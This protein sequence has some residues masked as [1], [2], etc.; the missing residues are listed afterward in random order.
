[1]H[2]SGTSLLASLL[3]GAGLHMGDDLLGAGKGNPEGHFE[4][5]EFYRLHLRM[6][7]G[8]GLSADGFTSAESIGVPPPCHE[9][10]SELVER[11]R[12]AGRPWGWK[13]PR[14]ILFLDFWADLLPESRWLFVV[15]PPWEV[16][17]S[18]YRRG[19]TAFLANPRFAA[20]VWVAYN[21]RIL[22]FV[23]SM[24]ARAAVVHTEQVIGDPAGV[25]QLAAE[26][27]C[28]PLASPPTRF[29]KEL[30]VTGLPAHCA[31]LVH[32]ANPETLPIYRDLLACAYRDRQPGSETAVPC[33]SDAVA[34]AGMIE[35]S[36]A[37]TVR[38]E[39]DDTITRM[40]IDRN[41]LTAERTR[42]QAEC[43]AL[44]SQLDAE[45]S[46]CDSLRQELTARKSS[47]WSMWRR[48]A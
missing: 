22:K 44:A 46:L 43:A 37:C 19:D 8:N 48:F 47:F 3:A 7:A 12:A 2:R 34:T 28:T 30:F 13:E 15:R 1:M 36:R 39:R 18:L 42:L 17:D 29:R 27:A 20:D 25:I 40:R 24:P 10:A 26:L 41:A 16:V 23:R 5:K 6:L 33:D 38:A 11:R 9:D 31:A 21:R 14:T 32:G 4:D 45:R 35:W